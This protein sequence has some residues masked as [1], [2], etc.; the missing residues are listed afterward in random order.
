MAL[1]NTLESVTTPVSLHAEP[2]S[3]LLDVAGWLVFAGLVAWLFMLLPSTSFVPGN[4]DYLLAIGALG[5]WRYSLRLVH[6]VR[7]MIFLRSEYPRIKAR[8]Q[9]VGE[10][11]A[12]SH[13]YVLLTSFRIDTQTSAEVYRAAI[14]EAV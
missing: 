7:A 1:A 8:A 3:L 11:A 6:F 4:R 10:A 5:I 13:V 9:S 2:R 14:E 12:P